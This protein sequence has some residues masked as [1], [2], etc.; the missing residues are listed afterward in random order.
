MLGEELPNYMYTRLKE[1]GKLYISNNQGKPQTNLTLS[2]NPAIILIH[3]P[4][5][6]VYQLSEAERQELNTLKLPI[7]CVGNFRR[8]SQ[9]YI[10][11]RYTED[12]PY[13]NRVYICGVFDSFTLIGDYFRREWNV[14]ISDDLD[15]P[16]YSYLDS[17][18]QEISE[19]GISVNYSTGF[20]RH[21]I[22]T[23]ST[24]DEYA[25]QPD[26]VAV[27]LG[28]NKIMHQYLDR[29]SCVEELSTYMKTKI[30]AIYR[31]PQV[32]RLLEAH[33]DHVTVG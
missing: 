3:R 20:Q 30:F 11:D 31:V 27:Y 23:F 7:L 22:I 10:P 13:L 9:I 15:H 19:A 26:H 14:W 12:H 25:G 2:D 29:F 24:Q 17:N 33:G 21:D 16:T 6:D 28:N 32:L 8:L 18:G 4:N 5:N 1:N